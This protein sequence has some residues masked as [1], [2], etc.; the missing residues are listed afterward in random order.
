MT[1]RA[2]VAIA[3]PRAT[4]RN[5]ICEWLRQTG[6]EP[7]ILTDL[8]RLEEQFQAAPIE[9]LVADL[10]LAPREADIRDLVRRLGAN[11]P[12]IAIGEGGHLRMSLRNDLSL[13]ARPFTREGVIIAVGL[14]LAEGR[15]ARRYP[16]KPVEPIPATANGL[17]ATIRE[18]S[19][20]GVGI[21][22]SGARG[23]VLPPFFRLRVPEFGVHCIVKRAWLT[24]SD[25]VRCGGT[26]EGDLP[27][28]ARTWAE[29]AREAPAPV[30][31]V[32]R[33]WAVQ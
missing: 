6:Y 17:T 5:A 23:N 11:R 8:A 7:I 26:V 32:A 15:P 14:A 20:G 18:A 13:L 12:L 29:F 16:R 3:C 24:A 31:L 19:I 4:E 22:L 33:H 9:A 10:V 25:V 27:D 30:T 21:E 28:A 1:D 2:T